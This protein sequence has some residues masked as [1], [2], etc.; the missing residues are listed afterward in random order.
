[1]RAAVTIPGR[2]GHG[3]EQMSWSGTRRRRCRHACPPRWRWPPISLGFSPLPVVA[4]KKGFPG[5]DRVPLM[6]GRDIRWCCGF[7]WMV[8]CVLEIFLKEFISSAL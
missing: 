4:L 8:S 2:P 7:R 3:V 6:A 1:V 5:H